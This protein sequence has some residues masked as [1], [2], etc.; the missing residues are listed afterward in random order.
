MSEQ[1]QN[2]DSSEQTQNIG[3]QLKPLF[4]VHN[5]NKIYKKLAIVTH[6]IDG[7][8]SFYQAI[9]DVPRFVPIIDFRYWKLITS[10]QDENIEPSE[11]EPSEP[12]EPEPTGPD[13][14]CFTAEND[15]SSLRVQVIGAPLI[16]DTF[17][18]E[19]SLDKETWT[20]VE[21]N[22]TSTDTYS[23][24]VITSD[25]FEFDK[26][27]KLYFRGN[28]IDGTFKKNDDESAYNQLGYIAN[29]VSGDMN[30][31]SI[32]SVS[33][34]LQTLVDETGEDKEHGC[35]YN[36]FNYHV[37]W[38]YII[39]P[40][41]LTA[42][43]LNGYMYTGL[44]SDQMYLKRAANITQISTTDLLNRNDFDDLYFSIEG[45]YTGS[46]GAFSYMYNN[47]ISL[48]DCSEFNNITCETEDDYYDKLYDHFNSTYLGTYVKISNDGGVTLNGFDNLSINPDTCGADNIDF[49]QY[50]LNAYRGVCN[51][52]KII[53]L[54]TSNENAADARISGIDSWSKFFTKTLSDNDNL[55]GI[56][57]AYN[58]TDNVGSNCSIGNL[59]I[60]DSTT[61]SSIPLKVYKSY[62]EENWTD[63][64]DG[65]QNNTLAITLEDKPLT[66]Y[67]IVKP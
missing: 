55:E 65:I 57:T 28:N 35:F 5:Y 40:P 42:T 21:F 36:L 37:C 16:V 47:C 44:F 67:K 62:D 18:L 29:F 11:P 19:Y 32:F 23:N 45:E 50:V 64:S 4:E 43:K 49:A 7:E 20:S 17:S 3:V 31:P 66:V 2:L 24:N 10:V 14:L 60:F 53:D 34:D 54:T 6:T 38:L 15:N 51:E 59:S 39:T 12:I 48:E 56:I 52:L 30:N 41:D 27:D 9:R 25:V 63:V 1:T 26:D 8:L 46:K 61:S 33:G 13:Y 22:N 58:V